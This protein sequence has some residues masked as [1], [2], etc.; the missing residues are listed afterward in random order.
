[1]KLSNSFSM[2]IRNIL[3]SA[4]VLEKEFVTA[5]QEKIRNG[6]ADFRSDVVCKKCSGSR[7]CETANSVFL[8][9]F[10]IGQI[11]AKSVCDAKPFFDEIVAE[12]NEEQLAIASPIV[13]EI[14]KRLQ[15]LIDV[16]AEYLTID[17]RA[18]T[19]SGGEYQRVRLATGI[20]SG[21][22]GCLLRFR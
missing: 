2:A 18:N 8:G 16:G 20:G 21:L 15:F 6:L 22:T 10:S 13:A 12:L 9:E 4:N 11:A 5:T 19:L 14:Q 7:L 17:R 1:M 3:D